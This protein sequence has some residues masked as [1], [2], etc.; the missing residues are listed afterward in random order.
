VT[1]PVCAA[2]NAMQLLMRSIVC[3]NVRAA[4]GNG[5]C[6]KNAATSSREAASQK[7]P[8]D[9][10]IVVSPPKMVTF[11]SSSVQCAFTNAHARARYDS[12]AMN[13]VR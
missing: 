2:L 3:V 9:A 10:V 6:L 7:F 12:S 8:S 11:G 4:D 13:V 1:L 5:C